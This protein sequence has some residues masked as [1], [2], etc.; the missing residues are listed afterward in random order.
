MQDRSTV[1]IPS[2]KCCTG[3]LTAVNVGHN[4]YEIGNWRTPRHRLSKGTYVR[5]Y[6]AKFPPSEPVEEWDS[7]NL[8]YS[9]RYELHAAVIFRSTELRHMY[10][11]LD[12]SYVTERECVPLTT[13]CRLLAYLTA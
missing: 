12:T 3:H 13:A 11:L 7:R 10:V 9:L 5:M 1:G 8:L 2:N 6:L 4:E